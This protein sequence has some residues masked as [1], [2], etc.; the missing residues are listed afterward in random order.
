MILLL[1]LLIVSSVYA[2]EVLINKGS[3][4]TLEEFPLKVKYVSEEDS[5]YI[6]EVEHAEDPE[7][8]KAEISISGAEPAYYTCKDVNYVFALVKPSRNMITFSVEEIGEVPEPEP[9]PEEEEEVV[10]EEEEEE[11]PK[12]TPFKTVS[13]CDGCEIGGSCVEEGV[14]KQEKVGGP[15]YYCGPDQKVML[16][17]DIGEICMADYECQFYYC[18][19]G[20][21]DAKMEGEGT[22]GILIGVFI[23][24]VVILL[25]VVFLM[26]KMGIGFKKITK[27]EEKMEK[28]QKK[29]AAWQTSVQGIKRGGPYKYRSEFDV[30]EKKMRERLRK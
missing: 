12:G 16:A 2:V 10:E 27:A 30:L 13:L 6:L 22:K 28:E 9:E 3:T 26:Y 4:R 18:N 1:F 24:V 11:K 7:C 5:N 15:I 17:K 25:I 21:C 29:Q 20:Y 8:E 23:G 19:N 14:Q